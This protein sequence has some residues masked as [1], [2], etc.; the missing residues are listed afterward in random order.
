MVRAGVVNH[1]SEWPY[2]GY[3]ETQ[4]PPPRKSL[5]DHESLNGLLGVRSRDKLKEA[6]RVWVS[7][8]LE[9]ENYRERQPWWTESIAFGSEGFVR[10]V[11]EKLGV[12]AMWPEIKGGNGSEELRESPATYGS[13]FARKNE[14]LRQENVFFWDISL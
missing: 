12:K 3:H 13:D 8:G 7:E 11:R 1:P 10:E 4:N 14:G 5:I 2:C 6:Y 9:K